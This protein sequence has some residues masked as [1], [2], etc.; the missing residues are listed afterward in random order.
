MDELF[1]DVNEA[2]ARVLKVNGC[3]VE[4]PTGQ[5]CCGSLHEHAGFKDKAREL[6]RKNVD[7]LEDGSD[8]PIIVNAAGC[9]ALLKEYGE[10]LGDD[11][12]YSERAKRLSARVKDLTEFLADGTVVAGAPLK[13]RV[14]WDAPC[15]LFHAQRVQATPLRIFQAIP[16]LEL[17]ALRGSE[18]CCGSGGIYSLTHPEIADEVL[19]DKLDAI[20]EARAEVVLTANPGCQMQI[21]AGLRMSGSQIR[22]MHIVELLDESYAAAGYYDGKNPA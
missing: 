8:A 7:T 1:H 20:H 16:E 18:R 14:T 4:V 11:P 13:R 3:V 19:A 2:T 22:V 17:V 6:A 12:A 5:G 9:G 10:L 21:Q 15:H